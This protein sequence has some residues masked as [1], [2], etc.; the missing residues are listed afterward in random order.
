MS[1]DIDNVVVTI[2][3]VV[4]FDTKCVLPLLYLENMMSVRGVEYESFKV[5]FG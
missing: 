4:E 5:Q 3:T 1:K 2:R